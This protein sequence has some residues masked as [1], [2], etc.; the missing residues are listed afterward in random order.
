LIGRET[1]AAMA[2]ESAV[3]KPE[4][5]KSV[6]EK[7]RKQPEIALLGPGSAGN[8]SISNQIRLKRRIPRERWQNNTNEVAEGWQS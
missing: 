4:M 1:L 6:T 5:A 8:S 7:P 3:E 2:G